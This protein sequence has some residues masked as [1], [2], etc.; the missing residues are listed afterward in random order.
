MNDRPSPR[1]YVSVDNGAALLGVRPS[2]IRRAILRGDLKPRRFCG[3]VRVALVDLEMLVHED[4]PPMS[5]RD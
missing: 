1:R 5:S 4:A 3:D 2:T